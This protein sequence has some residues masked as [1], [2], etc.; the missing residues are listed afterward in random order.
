MRL[1]P[2][3]GPAESW[4]HDVRRW[5]G[6]WPEV[7]RRT[8]NTRELR[9]RLCMGLKRS[10]L[11]SPSGRNA[12]RAA[13]DLGGRVFRMAR[14]DNTKIPTMIASTVSSIMDA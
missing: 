3:S 8:Q 12:A 9:V 13:S 2:W 6:P 7:C 5:R 11:Y 10:S 4:S 1:S 14:I